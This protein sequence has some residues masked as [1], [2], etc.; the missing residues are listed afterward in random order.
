VS[1]DANRSSGVPAPPSQDTHSVKQEDWPRHCLWDGG[2][3]TVCDGPEGHEGGC[4]LVPATDLIRK[5][6]TD[7]LTTSHYAGEQRNNLR[8]ARDV[9]HGFVV[10]V[11]D[12]GM[13]R[14]MPDELPLLNE[15]A[16]LANPGQEGT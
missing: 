14:F 12:R 8:A 3:R 11:R 13:G 15:M 9:M 10:L 6:E 16:R 4:R 5:L 1:A 2:N 7:L